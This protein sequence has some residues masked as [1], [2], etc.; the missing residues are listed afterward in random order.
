MDSRVRLW[1]VLLDLIN[2]FCVWISKKL[3]CFTPCRVLQKCLPRVCGRC[4]ISI[5][6]RQFTDTL[7]LTILPCH[8]ETRKVNI[9]HLMFL[10]PFVRTC[11]TC[12]KY[13]REPPQVPRLGCPS[14]SSAARYHLVK[15]GNKEFPKMG[16]WRISQIWKLRSLP[17]GKWE[18][19][20][21]GNLKISPNFPKSWKFSRSF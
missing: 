20:Q 1:L 3:H 7:L 16:K 2:S 8:K 19:C 10:N 12:F 13:V 15:W 11:F 14:P 21:M 18:I 6:G 5:L 4:L 17:I 9:L